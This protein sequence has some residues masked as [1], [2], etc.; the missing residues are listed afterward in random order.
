MQVKGNGQGWERRRA[1]VG[2]VGVAAAS[3][4]VKSAWAGAYEDFFAALRR[5]DMRA[6]EQLRVRGFDLNTVDE[7]GQPPLLLAIRLQ[8]WRAATFLVEQPGVDLDARNASGENALML[9]ALRGR[10]EL[11][12]RLL[13]RGAE[14]NQPGWAPLH[15]AAAHAGAVDG[16]G[17]EMVAL[18]LEHSA[19]ID[20]ESPNGTTPLMMAARYGEAGAVRVLLESDADPTLRNQ[21][22]LGALEFATA[23][24]RE[25]VARLIARAL[26][27]RLGPASW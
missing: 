18:L 4:W 3:L 17:A 9:A 22:R 5:D 15:Y 23:A 14:V 7:S 12:R 25:S 16:A 6:L 11:L 20:A 27:A 8:A 10:I 19:Y 2:L 24:G 1:L 13:D 21:Q 26:R